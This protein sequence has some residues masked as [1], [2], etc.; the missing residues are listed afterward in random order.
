MPCDCRSHH[1]N[2]NDEDRM[3]KFSSYRVFPLSLTRAWKSLSNEYKFFALC[4]Q[5]IICRHWIV[6]NQEDWLHFHIFI[7]IKLEVN[8]KASNKK[9]HY[10]AQ[11]YLNWE[12]A[13][14]QNQGADREKSIV[15]Y[16]K[17]PAPEWN[18][19]KRAGL[20]RTS[21]NDFDLSNGTHLIHD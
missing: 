6:F 14:M 20:H 15:K 21:F 12:S 17:M 8:F 13:T 7:F 2:N 18:W 9:C 5:F 3:A 4:V 1:N 19:K 11:G 16:S 10:L